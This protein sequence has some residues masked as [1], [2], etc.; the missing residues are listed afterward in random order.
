MSTVQPCAN[1]G[2]ALVPSHHIP[3]MLFPLYCTAPHS[4][5]T[6]G[7]YV[8]AI[9]V[10]LCHWCTHGSSSP[11][12]PRSTSCTHV[13]SLL[14]LQSRKDKERL[15]QKHK[16]RPESPPSILTPPVVPTADKVLLPTG[17]SQDM[18]S[19]LGWRGESQSTQGTPAP[20]PWLQIHVS[21]CCTSSLLM[22]LE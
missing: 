19:V 11:R 3:H 8:P 15:K 6:P 22:P 16:K 1:P 17:R 7:R 13:P 4:R 9:D 10:A 12:A 20:F 2:H 21:P 14:P 5:G 18:P